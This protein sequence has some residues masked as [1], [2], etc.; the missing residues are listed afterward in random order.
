MG[1]SP[2]TDS[3]ATPRDAVVRDSSPEYIDRPEFDTDEVVDWDCPCCGEYGSDDRRTA[4]YYPICTNQDCPVY[5]FT[6]FRG[7]ADAE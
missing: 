5:L 6:V 2:M 3:D 7:E 4:D 1:V